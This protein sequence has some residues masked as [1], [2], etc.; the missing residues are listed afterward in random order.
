M[1]PGSPDHGRACHIEQCPCLRHLFFRLHNFIVTQITSMPC[2]H[3]KAH[4][5]GLGTGIQ[6]TTDVCCTRRSRTVAFLLSGNS[7]LYMQ[8]RGQTPQSRFPGPTATSHCSHMLR[9]LHEGASIAARKLKRAAELSYAALLLLLSIFSH[10]AADPS[11]QLRLFF[12]QKLPFI[13]EPLS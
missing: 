11:R 6:R 12:A 13:S 5:H 4:L 7:P 2:S 9:E 1:N 3:S 8:A 10:T